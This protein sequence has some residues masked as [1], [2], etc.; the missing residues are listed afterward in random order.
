MSTST[1]PP[2]PPPPPP[3]SHTSVNHNPTPHDSTRTERFDVVMASNLMST[4]AQIVTASSLAPTTTTIEDNDMRTNKI[5]LA[6][7][8]NH[9]RSNLN[10]L[11]QQSLQIK[12][13]HQSLND[14]D[15]LIDQLES[16]LKHKTQQLTTLNQLIPTVLTTQD[17][18]T[19]VIGSDDNVMQVD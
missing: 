9:L 13:A 14:Q 3:Q 4:L 6:R 1:T 16:T 19:H 15:W 17:S 11:S 10:T 18:S 12:A 7:M 5:E 8:T 2:P